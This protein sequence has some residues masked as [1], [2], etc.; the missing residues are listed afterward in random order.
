MDASG[1]AMPDAAMTR[2]ERFLVFAGMRN[3]GP[4]IVE[5]VSWYRMLGFDVLIGY[6]DC[7]DHSPDLIAALADAG[8]VTGVEHRP[9]EM[10]PKQSAYRACRGHA[11][12][13]VAD[14][15]LIC[16]VDEFLTLHVG[17]GGIASYLDQIGRDHP[18]VS[19]HWRCFG[20]SGHR[21]YDDVL[22][23]RAFTR[24]GPDHHRINASF[25]TMFREPLRYRRFGDHAPDRLEGRPGTGGLAFV[26]GEGRPIARF[27]DATEPVRMTET[28]EISH[29]FAQMNHY[30]LRT[31]ESFA[32]KRGMPSASAGVDRYTD[33]FYAARD[34]NGQRD[35]SAL[36]NAAAFD[37]I[38][39]QA[40][41]LP[42]VRRL[43]HLCCA[44]YV[45]R[46][47]AN[48]GRAAGDDPR[49]QHHMAEAARS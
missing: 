16:D 37:R 29:R 1:R 11:A 26:D 45:A 40:M 30:I 46:L 18:G 5:W 21:S 44:D 13:A 41:A 32:L 27:L 10:T 9:A 15:L 14:W 25:K 33:R 20:T 39:A 38:H 4:F 42:Q 49:W 8:W 35:L 24:C 23:H 31:P 43:H 48:Q 12:T 22:V 28:R 2:P 6:N 34:L 19:F 47:S 17:D 3:E 7:T 36:A